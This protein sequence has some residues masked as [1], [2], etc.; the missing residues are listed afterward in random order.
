MKRSAINSLLTFD[1]IKT[2]PENKYFERKSAQIRPSDLAPLISAFANADGGTIVIGIS[3]STRNFEGIN[4]CGEEKINDF[5]NAPK[6]YCRPMPK[7][8]EEFLEITNEQGKK[9]R[10]LLLHIT[11]STEKIIRTSSDKTFLRI[12]DKT[13]EM[14]GENLLSLE[15]SKN[16]RHFEDEICLNATMEDLDEELL[17][18]YK[19]RIGATG[20][21][22]HQVLSSRGFIAY[23]NGEEHLTNAA[24]L[25]FAKNIMKFHPNCRVRFVRINGREMRVGVNFNVVKDKSLDVPILRVIDQ[26]KAFIGDQLR[27]FRRQDVVTGLFKG[28]PEY[29][30][31]PWQEG[32]INAVAHRDY[33]LS[34]AYI[35]VAMYD[36]RLE[37]ESP[38][39]LPGIVNLDNIQHMRFSRNA[40]ISRVMT[41][42]EWVRELNEGVKKIYSDMEQD[43]LQPPE[44]KETPYS[45]T[46]ILRND[47]DRRTRIIESETPDAS[48][49]YKDIWPEL[50]ETEKTIMM[51]LLSNGPS[52][53]SKIANHIG[54]S[55]QTIVIRINH[56]IELGLI[57]AKGAKYSKNRTYEV[58]QP[59][60]RQY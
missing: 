31:F 48:Q 60:T 43:G 39:G 19:E 47:V 50:D 23:A 46:L 54:R 20:I 14:L 27:D 36:D 32:I 59:D 45:V 55:K 10:L 30:D 1:Y 21:D 51:F 22:T 13:K 15:Y 40:K 7:Y 16:T 12:G 28:S 41:E 37:I 24:V 17:E 9:D 26:A 52:E 8:Q 57:T 33:S 2:E 3:D 6:D 4:S 53:R 35:K 25:L 11:S 58:V 18:K 34:G 29:P 44:Y 42:F 49:I 38:G 5:I 56:L